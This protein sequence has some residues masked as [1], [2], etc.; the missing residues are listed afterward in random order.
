[1]I[2]FNKLTNQEY[3]ELIIKKGRW[4]G[5]SPYNEKVLEHVS[6][7]VNYVGLEKQASILDIGTGFGHY[8]IPL[9]LNGYNITCLDA[10]NNSLEI[11]KQNMSIFDCPF[12]KAIFAADVFDFNFSNKYDAVIG[13][14]ILHH[15]VN[16]KNDLA[17][18]E[19]LF[20]KFKGILKPG[21]IIA[22]VEPKYT[23]CYRIYVMLSLSMNWN[24]EKGALFMNENILVNMLKKSGYMDIH[25][26]KGKKLLDQVIL[27][28]KIGEI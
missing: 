6:D 3:F 18:L 20:R 13:F 8:T 2:L 14:G 16:N 15:I 17:N 12:P 23:L 10:N 1:M 11:F 19:K 5:Y 9:L 28:A 26:R 25:F 22:F 21:G 24:S 27:K 7:F 4:K